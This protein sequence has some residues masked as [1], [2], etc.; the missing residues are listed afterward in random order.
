MNTD[1]HGLEAG[2]IYTRLLLVCSYR[3]LS[4]LSV[5]EKQFHAQIEHG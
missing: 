2:N 1:K 3:F 5:A 4:V